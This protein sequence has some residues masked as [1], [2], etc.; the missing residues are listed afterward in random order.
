MIF[1]IGVPSNVSTQL[2]IKREAATY[3]DLLQF[4][5]TE[6]YFNITLKAIAELHWSARH[7]NGSAYL[8]RV[9][10]DV[11]VNVPRLAAG[12]A[13]G[14]FRPGLTGQVEVTE[15]HREPDNKWYMPPQYYPAGLFETGSSNFLVIRLLLYPTD[16]YPFLKGFGY[17]LST[18]R[19]PK[20]LTSMD[21]YRGFVLDIDDI[22][23][24]GIL[25]DY[26]Q[27]ERHHD[28]GFRHYCG[29]DVCVLEN[30]LVIY[31]CAFSS[32]AEAM[33][34]EWKKLDSSSRDHCLSTEVLELV[35][36]ETSGSNSTELVNE[37]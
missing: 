34:E 15:A 37:V 35:D 28:A 3:G 12:I 30:S 6:A 19:L 5:F 20:L 13:E 26:A 18:D 14:K 29:G 23:V 4:A 1:V 21:R 31:G 32:E 27:I 36:T 11:L 22:Y 2:A 24:T 7:C 9:D 17:L 8:L 33:Y 10:D 16:S 25:A